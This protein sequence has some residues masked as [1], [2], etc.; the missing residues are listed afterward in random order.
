MM[1]T[2]EAGPMSESRTIVV[3]IIGTGV[4]LGALLI[5]LVINQ[6]LRID[7]LRGNLTGQID[8]VKTDNGVGAGDGP[9]HAGALEPCADLLA[10][11]LD[12]RSS[13]RRRRGGARSPATNARRPSRRPLSRGTMRLGFPRLGRL[14]TSLWRLD[15]AQVGMAGRAVVERADASA[16]D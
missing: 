7:D 9:A 2:V 8:D 6:N 10:S 1:A 11:G 3:T 14:L 15:S 5:G 13:A 4:A 16:P 12:G